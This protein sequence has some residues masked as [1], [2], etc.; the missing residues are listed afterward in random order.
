VN[1]ERGALV[2]VELDPTIGNEQGRRR[3]CIVLTPSDLVAEQRYPIVVVVPCTS[4]T[5]LGPLYPILSPYP[6]GI[7]RPS[8]VLVDQVRAIDKQR[9]RGRLEPVPASE[10]GK[11]DGALRRAL[12]L[13]N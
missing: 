5:G 12:G 10:M 13:Q 6:G 7:T 1:L 3:P 4:R 9:V 8:S 11:V 2:M